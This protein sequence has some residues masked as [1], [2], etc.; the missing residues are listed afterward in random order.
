MLCSNFSVTVIRLAEIAYIYNFSRAA[1]AENARRM[2]Q[3]Y[4]AAIADLEQ[5]PE[6]TEEEVARRHTANIKWDGNLKHK[7]KRKVITNGASLETESSD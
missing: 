3:D 4:L 6:V 5:N 1:C 7:L 2:T